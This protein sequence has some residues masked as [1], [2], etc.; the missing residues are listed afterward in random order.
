MF[1]NEQL[2]DERCNLPN[3]HRLENPIGF[4]YVSLKQQLIIS[5]VC[6]PHEHRW[7]QNY[8]KVV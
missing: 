1:A 8:D 3:K 4:L 6:A 2:C 5:I 7:D